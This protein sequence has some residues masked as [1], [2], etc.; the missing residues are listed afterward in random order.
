MAALFKGIMRS[1]YSNFTIERIFAPDFSVPPILAHAKFFVDILD[2]LIK[3]ALVVMKQVHTEGLT[4]FSMNA[5][6]KSN[7]TD[8]KA[9]CQIAEA[10]EAVREECVHSPVPERLLLP[11]PTRLFRGLVRIERLPIII[12][13]LL[14]LLLS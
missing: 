12:L 13:S 3:F 10:T 5:S 14:P 11:I 4:G 9:G 6:S 7:C 1:Y 2:Y 8:I